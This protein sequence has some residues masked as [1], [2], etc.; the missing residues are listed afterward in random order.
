MADSEPIPENDE[1]PAII[2]SRTNNSEGRKNPE[3]LASKVDKEASSRVQEQEIDDFGL[4]AKRINRQSPSPVK[5]KTPSED[6]GSKSKEQAAQQI[7]AQD[8]SR[9]FKPALNS[10][11]ATQHAPQPSPGTS[12]SQYGDN[13]IQPAIP[14][15]SKASQEPVKSE[16]I[17]LP[18]ADDILHGHTGAVSGWSHQALAPQKIE[19]KDEKAEEDW[20]NMPSYASYDLYDD[21]GHLIAR[22]A[23]ESDDEANVYAGLGGAGKGYT[24]VQI[25][26]DAK[27]ATSMDDNTDYLF[28]IKKTDLADEDDEQ[29]DPLAQLQATKGLLTEGQRI[30]YVGVTRLAMAMMIK[31]LEGIEV[32]KNTKKGLGV[33]IESMKMWHQKMMVR[34][35]MHM[36]IDSSGRWMCCQFYRSA[37]WKQN[38]L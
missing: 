23:P 17:G 25:D 4:P 3:A 36:E 34:L 28:K 7:S 32:T 22:E 38:K 10:E 26:E 30:A 2:G 5:D 6:E 35:Y 29:R 11:K 16:D 13:A 1:P 14:Q 8:A 31:E 20:Q 19:A 27:S 9:V 24:R 33:A 15:L 12:E 21:D 37:D 18:A